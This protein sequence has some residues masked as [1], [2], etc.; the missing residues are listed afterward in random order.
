MYK[1]WKRR[2]YSFIEN[3]IIYVEKSPEKCVGKLLEWKSELNEV[4]SMYFY[5]LQTKIEQQKL[6]FIIKIYQL[7]GVNLLKDV[8]KSAQKAIKH[9][10]CI[11]SNS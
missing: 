6:Y 7:K 3:V 11:F 4:K 1:A 9:Y 8:Q 5:I 2:N 10:W